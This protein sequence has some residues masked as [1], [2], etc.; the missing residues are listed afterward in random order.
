MHITYATDTL[1]QRCL[2]AL[3]SQLTE[4]EISDLHAILS[5]LDAAE[6]LDDLPGDPAT[7]GSNPKNRGSMDPAGCAS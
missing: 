6:R 5:D 4:D 3:P 1:M 2:S 7:R